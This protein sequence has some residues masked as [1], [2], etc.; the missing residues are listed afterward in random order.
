M[1][2]LLLRFEKLYFN[3]KI[4]YVCRQLFQQNF[5]N[6]K[7]LPTIQMVSHTPTNHSDF[8][9]VGHQKFFSY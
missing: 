7:K 2:L 3:R 5:T 1:R 4:N 9:K 8:E 6:I